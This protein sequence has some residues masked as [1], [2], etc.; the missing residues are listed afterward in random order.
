MRSDVCTLITLYAEG[1]EQ[2]RKELEVFCEKKSV[3]RTERYSAYA[4]GLRLRF[5]LVVDPNDYEAVSGPEGELP[6]MVQYGN[7][8]YNIYHD[9]QTDES[10]ME[11]TVG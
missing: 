2:K 4:V 7:H 9:Y 8:E 1:N 3:S 6:S 11:L 5:V 10:S